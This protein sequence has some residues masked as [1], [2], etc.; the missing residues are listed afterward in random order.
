MPQPTLT[1]IVAAT[2]HLGIGLSGGLPWR[3][4]SEMAYFARVTKRIH[5]PMATSPTNNA[6]TSS[7]AMPPLTAANAVIMGRKTWSS[8]PP[9]FRPLPGRIN[10]V[11][12]RQPT[13]PKA[14]NAGDGEETGEEGGVWGPHHVNSLDEA[15]GLVATGLG[16][17]VEV[18]RV[19]V[20]G[21]AEIYRLALAHP[22]TKRILVTEV[23]KEEG[24][25]E[26]GAG[27]GAGEDPFKCDTFF[28]EFRT[29]GRGWARKSQGELSAYVGEEVQPGWQSE[30]DV[31]FEYQLWE[32]E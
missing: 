32:K 9:K 19:F 16:G 2:S 26:A 27:V 23:T 25:E 4:K 21:G 8:I 7:N 31:R 15:L 28:P 24:G 14:S 10:I 17:K 13:K 30:K 22:R 20:I 12:T 1:L 11:I 29:S 3:L 6:N 5:P 18:G